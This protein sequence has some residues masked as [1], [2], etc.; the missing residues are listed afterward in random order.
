MHKTCNFSFCHNVFHF[1]SYVIHSIIEIFQFLT[2]YVQS[3]LLQNCRMRE[4][5]TNVWSWKH[6]LWHKKTAVSASECGKGVLMHYLFWNY[7]LSGNSIFNILMI[8]ILIISLWCTFDTAGRKW[9][10][11]KRYQESMKEKT[12]RSRRS[13]SARR[14]WRQ[15]QVICRDCVKWFI[16]SSQILIWP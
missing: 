12:R 16:S 8:F 6:L 4:S 13:G 7:F 10:K 2:K 5:I 3:C 15:R 11:M 14:N 9:V 1:K